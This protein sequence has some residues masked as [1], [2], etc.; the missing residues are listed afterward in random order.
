VADVDI[1][2]DLAE[3]PAAGPQPLRRILP[4]RDTPNKSVALPGF[5]PGLRDSESRVLTT[6]LQSKVC[7]QAMFTCQIFMLRGLKCRI[8]DNPR[9]EHLAAECWPGPPLASRHRRRSL[10]EMSCRPAEHR[11]P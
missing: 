9:T 6:T 4:M 11:C 7:L 10:S 3:D 1:I 8:Q 5:E 2:F